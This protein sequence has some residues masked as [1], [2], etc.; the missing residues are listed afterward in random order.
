MSHFLNGLV[1]FA[2][3]KDD[4]RPPAPLDIP[5]TNNVI[6]KKLRVA[7]EL[8]EEDMLSLIGVTGLQIGKSELSAF[9]RSK[10]HRNYRECGDQ[11]LRNLFKGLTEKVKSK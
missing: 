5:V 3:G 10:D 1:I 2:R 4:S 7:F 6:L 8:R 9:L 11:V